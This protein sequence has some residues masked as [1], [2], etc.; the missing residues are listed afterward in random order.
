MENPVIIDCVIAGKV[1]TP[2][3]PFA[4]N[5]LS[6]LEAVYRFNWVVGHEHTKLLNRLKLPVVL[7]LLYANRLSLQDVIELSLGDLTAL[8]SPALEKILMR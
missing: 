8:D 7:K 3:N 4:T 5:N 6:P 1:D 2:E